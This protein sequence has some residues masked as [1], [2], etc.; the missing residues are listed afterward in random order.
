MKRSPYP[1][2]A[3]P[4]LQARVNLQWLA[5]MRPGEVC[6][7][8]L[9]EIDQAG[10]VVDGV[11]TWVYRPVQHKNAHRG[12]KRAIAFG[13]RAQEILRPFLLGREPGTCL[14]AMPRQ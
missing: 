1:C 12:Y 4:V 13:P 2:R 9:G 6:G 10:P 14:F 8:T 3:G 5:G 11:R 7:L